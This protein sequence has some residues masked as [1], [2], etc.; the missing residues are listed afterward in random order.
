MA[1]CLEEQRTGH[2]SV[3]NEMF[4]TQCQCILLE[5]N[6]WVQGLLGQRGLFLTQ[7][8]CVAGGGSGC[9]CVYV[10]FGAWGLFK[11]PLP[12]GNE[13]VVCHLH[14][15]YAKVSFVIQ[16]AAQFLRKDCQYLLI[17]K[18]YLPVC[19]KVEEKWWRAGGCRARTGSRHCAGRE[20]S[21][22]CWEPDLQGIGRDLLLIKP[23]SHPPNLQ[24][25]AVP[26]PSSPSSQQPCAVGP[27]DGDIPKRES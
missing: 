26:P 13:R 9:P 7:Q 10:T 8:D 14:S 27:V 17:Y 18:K 21:T 11:P 1:L 23:S 12:L 3:R 6:P 15:R 4:P 19:V 20:R 5:L 22:G 2:G 16:C 25:P 24:P